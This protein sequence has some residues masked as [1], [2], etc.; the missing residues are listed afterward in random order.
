[1]ASVLRQREGETTTSKVHPHL[2]SPVWQCWRNSPIK[3][4]FHTLLPVCNVAWVYKS[5]RNTSTGQ[6]SRHPCYRVTSAAGYG[7]W[8][9]LQ[10][11]QQPGQ[12]GISLCNSGVKSVLEATASGLQ[13]WV[14]PIGFSFLSGVYFCSPLMGSSCHSASS[15]LACGT[16]LFP[17]KSNES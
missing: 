12:G 16:D 13:L 4:V 2:P 6:R 1:M 5:I 15:P 10:H 11:R 9:Q 17:L 8:A 3:P 14:R 7:L